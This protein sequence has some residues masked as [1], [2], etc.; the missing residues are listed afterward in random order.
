MSRA[1]KVL[2]S[3]G[4][5]PH[6]ELLR[7]TAPSFE[8]YARRHGY[9]VRVETDLV[10][11]ERPASWSKVKLIRSL[12]DTY[13][14]AFWV[15]ADAMIV[16]SSLDIADVVDTFDAGLVAHQIGPTRVP[17]LGIFA[18]RSTK[19]GKDFLDRV[20]AQVAYWDHKWWENAAA[21]HLLGYELEPEVRLV[22]PTPMLDRIA[23]LRSEWNSVVDDW[24]P[25]PRIVHYSGHDQ[26][27]RLLHLSRHRDEI[28]GAHRL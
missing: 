19:T 6:V 15:D 9:D 16:D 8:A 3:I 14:F 26:T 21:L 12:L 11:P 4:V 10:A 1:R 23:W 7:L 17:N 27:A 22:R 25:R 20:W 24:A 18:V 2:A 13:E 28:L 5:G